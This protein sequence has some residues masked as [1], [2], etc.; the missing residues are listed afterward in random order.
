MARTD[1]QR[2]DESIQY[3]VGK[4][5]ADLALSIKAALGARTDSAAG[6]EISLEGAGY[7]HHG[8]E[9]QHAAVRA[10]LLCH[11]AFLKAP[12]AVG[13]G[14]VPFDYNTQPNAAKTFFLTKSEDEVKEA[15]RC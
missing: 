14:G 15:I 13:A 3:I 11:K 7:W 5:S 8:N 4:I 9:G 12:Y 10:L 2:F 6:A 1:K